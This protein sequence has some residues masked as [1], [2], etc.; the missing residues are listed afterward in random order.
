VALGLVNLLPAPL[1][2]LLERRWSARRV[3]VA[4]PVAQAALALTIA[5]ST[6]FVPYAGAAMFFAAVLIF[7]HPFAFGL[8][9]GL[10]PSGRVLAATP[11]MLMVGSAIG[12]ILAGT[13]V[14]FHGYGSLGLAAV[15]IACIA[16]LCFS[17]AQRPQPAAAVVV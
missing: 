3:V 17:R 16:A 7:S 10:D 4:G 14:K 8:I 12:P 9:A 1:A 2:G 11:A 6:A 13:L 15:P 5:Q